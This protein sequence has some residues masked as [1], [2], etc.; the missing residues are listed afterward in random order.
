MIIDF[1]KNIR[2]AYEL[3]ANKRLLV[4]LFLFQMALRLRIMPI[5]LSMIREWGKTKW[6]NERALVLKRIQ[7]VL[8]S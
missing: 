6:E 4:Y 8:G 2:G 5:R 3:Y 1:K 7:M